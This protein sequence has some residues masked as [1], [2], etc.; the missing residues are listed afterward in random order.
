MFPASR[1]RI[2]TPTSLIRV[3]PAGRPV[4]RN[5]AGLG[6]GYHPNRPCYGLTE[7]W[8]DHAMVGPCYDRTTLRSDHAMVGPC[9]GWTMPWSDHAMVGPCSDGPKR[10]SHGPHRSRRVTAYPCGH[11]RSEP[12]QSRRVTAH[13]QVT[14]DSPS[15]TASDTP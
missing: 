3:T 5:F 10:I 9:H 13:R 4:S 1:N 2:P 12:R 6:L 15:V 11:G 8:S 14:V 7:L